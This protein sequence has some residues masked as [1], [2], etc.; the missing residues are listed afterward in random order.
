MCACVYVGG[1]VVTYLCVSENACGMCV[2]L[3]VGR[4]KEERKDLLYNKAV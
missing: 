3:K 4:G 1:G 2:S